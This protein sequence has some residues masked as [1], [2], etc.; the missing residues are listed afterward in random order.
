MASSNVTRSPIFDWRSSYGGVFVQ[1]DW[2]LTNRLTLNAGLRWDYESPTV[3]QGNQANAGFDPNVLALSC[4]A[5]PNSGLPQNLTGGLTF[6]DGA[7]SGR[8]LNNFGPR[9]G[10]TYRATQKM[11]VRGGYGL[12]Y[13]DA[14]TDRGTSTGFTRSTTFVASLDGKLASAPGPLCQ[15]V[16]FG[17]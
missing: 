10:F 8:D 4:P 9:V 2:R 13:L 17:G 7:F 11:V 15:F 1:D 12:T 5:C 3:E 6:A 14:S 16:T